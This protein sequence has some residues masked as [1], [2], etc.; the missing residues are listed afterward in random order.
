MS[1]AITNLWFYKY[2]WLYIREFI[3]Y[4]RAVGIPALSTQHLFV[5]RQHAHKRD[6]MYDPDIWEQLLLKF[7]VSLER[8]AW[9]KLY[10]C[11]S[12]DYLRCLS[13]QHTTAHP[14][15][16][17]C[18][19][20]SSGLWTSFLPLLQSLLPLPRFQHNWLWTRRQE[21]LYLVVAQICKATAY[22][23]LGHRGGQILKQKDKQPRVHYLESIWLPV[24]KLRGIFP[25][26]SD[27]SKSYIVF[28]MNNTCFIS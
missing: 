5:F 9:E 1:D 13:S 27:N 4:V 17:T 19:H 22:K 7:A 26:T 23:P 8:R 25:S 18:L 2:K 3:L 12:P 21:K 15:R 24:V 14:A 6:L 11:Y 20:P 10:F 16:V 28:N